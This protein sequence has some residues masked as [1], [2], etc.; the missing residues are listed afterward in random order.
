M[1]SIS[2]EI[3]KT[4][5]FYEFFLYSMKNKLK[6]DMNIDNNTSITFDKENS[7]VYIVVPDKIENY[8]EKIIINEWECIIKTIET[9]ENIIETLNYL[10]D[11]AK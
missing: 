4:K 6:F 10:K 3:F 9:E 8:D 7:S 11:L 1:E 5:I 2:N